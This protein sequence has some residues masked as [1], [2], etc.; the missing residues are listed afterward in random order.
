[1]ISIKP[2]VLWPHVPDAINL[3]NNQNIHPNKIIDCFRYGTSLFDCLFGVYRP[4]RDFSLIWTRH[5]YRWSALVAI[6]HLGFCS[7]PNL[8][9]Q[10]A[11]VYNGHLQGP[12]T[13][14]LI[15][16]G[17]AVE[18]SLPIFTTYVCRGWDSNTQFYAC[19]ANAL[20]HCATASVGR[21]N[22]SLLK[23]I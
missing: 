4:T 18:L 13:L 9:W 12:V 15:A 20:T 17:L 6:E 2:F 10:G 11:S 23:E 8:L 19:G 22:L 7:V 16:E 5:H 14:T 1:M 3:T 21:G